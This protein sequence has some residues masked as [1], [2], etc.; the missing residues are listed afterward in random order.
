VLYFARLIKVK[1][2]LAVTTGKISDA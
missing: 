1:V 2:Y